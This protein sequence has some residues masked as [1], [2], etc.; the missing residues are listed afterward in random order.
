V[1][2]ILYHPYSPTFQS[3]NLF[4][5][6][7]TTILGRKVWVVLD[8]LCQAACI[9]RTHGFE[10]AWHYLAQVLRRMPIL[11]AVL[12]AFES[13]KK[14]INNAK[15]G[16]ACKEQHST[17]QNTLTEYH[18]AKSSSYHLAKTS[19]PS[20]KQRQRHH[21]SSQQQLHGTPLAASVPAAP[22]RRRQLLLPLVAAQEHCTRVGPA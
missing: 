13:R 10:V 20:Q 6:S 15:D 12:S 8:C 7:L 4:R 14:L 1:R 18:Q 2:G 17:S 5:T 11:V 16:G 22:N 19:R 9:Q 3:S 21:N